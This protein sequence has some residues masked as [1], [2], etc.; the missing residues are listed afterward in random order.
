MWYL[1]KTQSSRPFIPT[2]QLG[3]V[4]SRQDD[5]REGQLVEHRPID[6]LV[7]ALD[8][9]G[10]EAVVGFERLGADNGLERV[11]GVGQGLLED[12][13]GRGGEQAGGGGGDDG[14]DEGEAYACLGWGGVW[15]GLQAG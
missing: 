10:M 1:H 9:P 13:R 8:I 3:L 15:R 14:D 12:A 11:D 4:G 6:Q 2:Y 5:R 7:S